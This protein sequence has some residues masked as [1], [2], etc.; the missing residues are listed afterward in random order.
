M[1]HCTYDNQTCY[2]ALSVP[3]IFDISASETY[4]SGGQNL[5][6]TGF[7]LDSPDILATLDGED[8]AVTQ[9][10]LHSFSCNVAEKSSISVTNS[11]RV[12]SNGIR[13][14]IYDYKNYMTMTGN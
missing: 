1:V 11:G 4:K 5:T 6:V 3:A 9:H 7:G 8:C 13:R 14:E 10:S 2:K 12:G